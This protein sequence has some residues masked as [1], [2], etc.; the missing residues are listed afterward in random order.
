[1]GKAARRWTLRSFAI[2]TLA[3]TGVFASASTAL[4]DWG[5]PDPITDQA[6]DI[7]SL[8]NLVT[9]M[10]IVVLVLV[11]GAFLYIL[12]RFRRGSRQEL[13]SQI[14]GN[15]SVEVLWTA[16]PVVIV[17][18]LFV[19]SFRVL[20]TLDKSA[21][22]EDLTV[23]VRGFQFCWTFTY[24][25]DDLGPGT[26]KAE[27]SVVSEEANCERAEP[28]VYMPVGERVEFRLESQDVIHSFFVRN[29]LYK[30]DVVPG[31]DNKFSVRARETGTFQ[32]QCA[33]LC[34]LD[35]AVMRFKLEVMERE[36]F[37]A[38]MAEL[39]AAQQKNAAAPR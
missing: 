36:Q 18:I 37:N 28:V 6:G 24:E 12:L 31:R 10:A 8:Y 26:E 32:G 15:N 19:F 4:A 14:H 16:I 33:E 1:M 39:R 3:L 38:K 30:L 29:F 34:G 23:H 20:L 11:E 22:P 27:G 2:T 25:L 35:H 21:K 7:Q 17:L 9:I 13:P 5:L